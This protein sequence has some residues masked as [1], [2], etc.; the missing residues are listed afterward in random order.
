[1]IRFRLF[2]KIGTVV[3]LVILCVGGGLIHIP[4]A[5]GQEKTRANLSSADSVS[6]STQSHWPVPMPDL[7]IQHYLKRIEIFE[8]ENAALPP[9]QKNVVFVG[10]SLTEGF[11]LQEYFPGTPV[12][13]RGIISDGIGFDERGVLNRMESSVFDCHPKAVILLIGVNDLPHSWASIDDCLKGY[14]DIVE[15]IQKRFP[16]VQIILCTLLPTGAK[17]KKHDTVNPRIIEFNQ[18][19]L[20]LAKEKKLALIDLY[21]L[22][23]DKDGL[24]QADITRDGLHITTEAYKPFAEQVKALLK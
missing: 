14:Q 18:G 15:Q 2:G 9:N 12:L 23:Q 24:L 10:D 3:S 19:V 17:Y 13:N 16:D 22:Y 11:P 6:E 8:K 20:A 7:W 1:M 4:P 21:S 5:Y